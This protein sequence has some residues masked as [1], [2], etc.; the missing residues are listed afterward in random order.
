MKQYT[1]NAYE[2]S[3]LS[4]DA[5]EIAKHW[6]LENSEREIDFRD[7]ILTDL[8]DY[9][10]LESPDVQFSLAGCQGDGVNIYGS[11]PLESFKKAAQSEEARNFPG[12][13][14]P[15]YTEK[16]WRTLEHYADICGDIFLP[17]NRHYCFPLSSQIDIFEDWTEKL[18]DAGFRS[19]NKPLLRRFERDFQAWHR[20]LCG[21]YER[22]G[23]DF[24]YNIDDDEMSE[25]CG[26]NCYYFDID[27]HFLPGV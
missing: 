5:K 24:L 4:Q 6:Y 2:F 14:L 3:E 11:I 1:L 15:K 25:I 26:S 17:Y 18:Q 16:E 19:I 27:G 12:V 13:F 9:Y 10:Y 20:S 8:A 23:H 21:Y 7:I 22:F